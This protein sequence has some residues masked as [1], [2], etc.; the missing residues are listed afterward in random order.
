MLFQDA[1]NDGDFNGWSVSPLGGQSRFSASSLFLAFQGGQHTQ[2]RTGNSAWS[3][4][5]VEATFP[6]HIAHRTTRVD[7]A[8]GSTSER[9]RDTRPGCCRPPGRSCST[10]WEGGPSTHRERS[11]LG[12]ATVTFDATAFHTLQLASTPHQI[13]VAYDGAPVITATD[14]VY[15]T[16][17]IAIDVS[18]QPVQWD[19]VLVTAP[20]STG[21]PTIGRISPTD[22]PPPGAP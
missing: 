9:E 3:D 5:S 18:S 12:R 13:Q 6:A 15:G 4:Y 20:A 14:S 19:D 10:G 1:F 22:G 11:V 21:P 7:S 16:G 2:L 8:A 17:A